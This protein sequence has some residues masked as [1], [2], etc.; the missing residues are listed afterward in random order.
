MSGPHSIQIYAHLTARRG[1]D[2][3]GNPL[4][5]VLIFARYT[6]LRLL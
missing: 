3:H 5:I 2:A 6:C 1:K 4:R